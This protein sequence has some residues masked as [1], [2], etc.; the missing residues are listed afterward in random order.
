ME[1]DRRAAA[2]GS[3]V[4]FN[5]LPLC[6]VALLCLAVTCLVAALTGAGG[7]ARGG[8]DAALSLS[9]VILLCTAIAIA[10]VR[11]HRVPSE[12]VLN[13]LKFAVL[14]CTCVC[15]VALPLNSTDSDVAL[16]WLGI[17]QS[18]VAALRLAIKLYLRA[19]MLHDKFIKKRLLITKTTT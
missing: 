9:A 2:V 5:A 3:I 7:S 11:P 16:T 8:C 12:N 1:A 17:A 18:V 10:V 4:R 14:G 19:E 6:I 15:R 13:P